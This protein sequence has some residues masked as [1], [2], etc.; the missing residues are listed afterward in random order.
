M[1]SAA[2]GP[3]GAVAAA[4]MSVSLVLGFAGARFAQGTSFV[5]ESMPS[6]A[7]ERT[8]AAGV[9]LLWLV[10]AVVIHWMMAVALHSTGIGMTLAPDQALYEMWGDLLLANWESRVPRDLSGVVGYNELSIYYA[11]N[12][13]VRFFSGRNSSFVISLVNGVVATV[14][15]KLAADIAGRLSGSAAQKVTFLLAALWPTMVVYSSLNLRDAFGW[16]FIM[17]VYSSALRLRQGLS[18]IS[19]ISLIAG[20]AG[21]GL[22]RP[23][24]LA[25]VLSGLMASLVVTRLRHIPYA[26]IFLLVTILAAGLL[27]ERFGLSRELFSMRSLELMESH[28]QNLNFGGSAAGDFGGDVSSVS[29]ALSYLPRGLLFFLLSP[30]PWDIRNL[31]QMLV[32]PELIVWYGVVILGLRGAVSL[33]RRAPEAGVLAVPTL[34]LTSAYALV[35]GNAGTANRH[36]AQVALVFFIFAAE[37][38]M[39]VL[40]A[41]RPSS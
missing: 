35:E 3:A 34:A 24:V 14:A 7:K 19:A 23:Y 41:R 1:A 36:R 6:S 38:L 10:A 32:L 33:F 2:L 9:P 30:F 11:A 17:L 28:R 5:R 12:A 16:M 13:V 31:R 18:V 8:E 26:A 29:G 21:V 22:I 20:L 39:R 37:G 40:P 25:L 27:G 4:G 15:A